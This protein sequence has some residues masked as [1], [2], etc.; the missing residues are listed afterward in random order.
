MPYHTYVTYEYVSSRMI[1]GYMESPGHS[2]MFMKTLM[3]K[4]LKTTN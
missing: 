1:D 3:K 4:K 2:H